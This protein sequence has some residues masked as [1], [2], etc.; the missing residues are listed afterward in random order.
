MT[1][2]SMG[3]VQAD[4]VFVSGLQRR[5]ELS[6][7]Q[8]GQAVAAVVQASGCS[9][10]AGQVAQE[11]GNHPDRSVIGVRWARNLACE[12]FADWPPG[13]G[14]GTD[15]EWLL[16]RLRRPAEQA[17]GTPAAGQRGPA[18]AAAGGEG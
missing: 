3:A 9:G 6:A 2:L 12:A 18:R 17:S 11:L 4:A 7:G 5:N 14:P 1:N 15:A 8:A 10:C 16:V 13:P